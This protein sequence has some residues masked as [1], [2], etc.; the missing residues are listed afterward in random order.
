MTSK[1]V[2]QFIIQFV[3]TNYFGWQSQ[4][5]VF[6]SIQENIELTFIK[7]GFKDFKVIGTS[8]TDRGVHAQNYEFLFLIEN[9]LKDLSKLLRSL[10]SL[11][12]DDVKV[13]AVHELSGIPERFNQKVYRYYFIENE[14]KPSPFIAPWVYCHHNPLDLNSMNLAAGLFLGTHSFRNFKVAGTITKTDVRTVFRSAIISHL[15][16][17]EFAPMALNPIHCYEVSADGFLKQMVRAMFG[18]LLRIGEHKISFH[19]LQ[20][21]LKGEQVARIATVAPGHGLH[22]VSTIHKINENSLLKENQNE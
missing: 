6:T 14:L 11:L 20:V 10:N 8:R 9:P 1:Y 7:L 19:D 16:L 22:L 4:K 13:L 12:N 15:D 18:A 2:Y 17:G 3:G 21:A 5:G